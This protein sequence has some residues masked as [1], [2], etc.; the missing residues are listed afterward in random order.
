MKES[1]GFLPYPLDAYRLIM[2]KT[3][4]GLSKA[5]ILPDDCSA[6]R[7]PVPRS[8]VECPNPE[9]LVCAYRWGYT[10]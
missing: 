3:L 9:E 10:L 6:L 5:F 2:E 1:L 8:V 7:C 4:E